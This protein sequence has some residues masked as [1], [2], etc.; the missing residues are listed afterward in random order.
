MALD[1][2]FNKGEDAASDSEDPCA[3]NDFP[4]QEYARHDLYSALG[5][6]C[7]GSLRGRTQRPCGPLVWAIATILVMEI[8]TPEVTLPYLNWKDRVFEWMRP[9]NVCSFPCN[10]KDAPF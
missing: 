7:L 9:A 8:S 4:L 10:N 6:S 3:T 1:D 2:F 5:I